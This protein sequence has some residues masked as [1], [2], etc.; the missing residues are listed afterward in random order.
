MGGS[1]QSLIWA[2]PICYVAFWACPSQVPPMQ[3]LARQVASVAERDLAVISVTERWRRSA[4]AQQQIDR[5][6]CR[7]RRRQ[8][9]RSYR[10]VLVVQLKLLGAWTHHRGD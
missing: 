3:N 10:F 7:A 1:R 8:H 5:H 6:R 4:D 9:V 2:R